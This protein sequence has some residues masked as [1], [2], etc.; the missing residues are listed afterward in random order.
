MAQYIEM[1]VHEP[2]SG[3]VT[4]YQKIEAGQVQIVT[5]QIISYV[6]AS[7][8]P[9]ELPAVYEMQPVTGEALDALP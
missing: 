2:G 7:G 6:D 1:L 8:Q 5:A 4:V 3:P 9:A